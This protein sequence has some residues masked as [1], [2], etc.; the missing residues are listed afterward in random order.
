MT[1]LCRSQGGVAKVA[2]SSRGK[3]PDRDP[4]AGGASTV[5]SDFSCPQFLPSFPSLFL[6]IFGSGHS[7]SPRRRQL[8]S[9]VKYLVPYAR[10][11]G[12][13]KR[14]PYICPLHSATTLQLPP[15]R[16]Y[17]GRS[18]PPAHARLQLAC[19]SRGFC[20][21]L[22]FTLRGPQKQPWPTTTPPSNPRLPS[23]KSRPSAYQN[24]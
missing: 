3:T 2:A 16:A 7:I 11:G 12:I 20:G 1:P 24:P 6:S 21:D 9:A 4:K 14:S 10:A 17:L 13:W 15:R 22:L 23:F 5:N 18:A 19:P 8:W